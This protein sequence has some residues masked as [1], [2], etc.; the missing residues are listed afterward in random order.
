MS[1]QAQTTLAPEEPRTL[2]LLNLVTAHFAVFSLLGLVVTVLCSMLFVYGYLKEF[3]SRLIWIIEYTD[4]LKFGLVALA[5]ISSAILAVILAMNFFYYTVFYFVALRAHEGKV[6]AAF[7][8]L[9]FFISSAIF[10]LV[11]FRIFGRE[12]FGAVTAV[13]TLPSE[14]FEPLTLSAIFL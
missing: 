6:Q 1:D 2:R 8:G 5:L 7:W 11:I 14:I 12:L 10:G 13:T 4:I 3:D 9:I